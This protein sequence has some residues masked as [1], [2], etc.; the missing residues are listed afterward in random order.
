MTIV[1]HRMCRQTDV[2]KSFDVE[3]GD[4]ESHAVGSKGQGTKRQCS[5]PGVVQPGHEEPRPDFD[6]CYQVT[7]REQWRGVSA[8]VTT[9]DGKVCVV[10]WYDNK[11]VLMLSV[12]R[13]E[14]PLDTCQRWCKKEKQY[15]TSMAPSTWKAECV[16]E[17]NAALGNRVPNTRDS[18]CSAACKLNATVENFRV[19]SKWKRNTHGRKSISVLG[20]WRKSMVL[21]K[22]SLDL[23]QNNWFALWQWQY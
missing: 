16:G 18:M 23:V 9:G 8:S 12:V 20:M 5:N 2:K 22:Q 19:T 15:L 1:N 6:A 21:Y 3:A 4:I 13:A 17:K 10:R 7:M 14:E 11:P